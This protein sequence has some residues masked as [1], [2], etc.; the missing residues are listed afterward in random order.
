MQ[1]GL[2]GS[3]SF[4]THVPGGIVTFHAMQRKR[5]SRWEDHVIHGRKPVP[6]Y[7]G[8]ALIEA[9][10]EM[11]LN[12]AWCNPQGAL[13]L[14]HLYQEQAL[15][16]PL[17]IGG[18]PF[19]PGLSLFSVREIDEKHVHWSRQGDVLKYEL[20]VNLTEYRAFQSGI[21]GGFL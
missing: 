3:V 16:M 1:V 12:T 4:G 18:K 10:I 5:S 19:G 20:G 7:L 21:L 8:P 9:Q 2:L 13:S 11:V 14:L 15:A 17:I 6:E